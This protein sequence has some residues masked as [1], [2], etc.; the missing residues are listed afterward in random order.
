MDPISNAREVVAALKLTAQRIEAHQQRMLYRMGERVKDKAVEYAPKGPTQEEKQSL[1]RATKAQWA[2][3]KK[4]RQP[5]ATTRANPGSLMR[6]IAFKATAK[7]AEIF[8]AANSPAGKYAFRIHEEKGLSWFKRGPG[9]V[10]KGAQADDKFITRAMADQR[11]ELE[12]I[13]EDQMNRAIQEA[14]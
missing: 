7:E 9:T 14:G 6:S 8:V 13:A 12:R 4:R 2:A 3:A 10:K 1:S 5:R 11:T